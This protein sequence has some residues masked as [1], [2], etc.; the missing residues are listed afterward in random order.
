MTI[1]NDKLTLSQA[2]I[3][4]QC[5]Q[6]AHR[7]DRTPEEVISNARK[8]LAWVGGS[9]PTTDESQPGDGSKEIKS[10]PRNRTSSPNP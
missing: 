6:L 10:A 2:E 8:Y 3:R 9:I 5:L 4:L 7:A 1:S